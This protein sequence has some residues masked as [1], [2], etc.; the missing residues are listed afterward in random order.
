MKKRLVAL[1]L[2]LTLVVCAFPISAFAAATTRAVGMFGTRDKPANGSNSDTNWYYSYYTN[3]AYWVG[4]RYSTAGKPVYMIQAYLFADGEFSTLLDI[5]GYFGN[6]TETKIRA[7]QYKYRNDGLSEDG[8]AGG[9]TWKH[10]A[11]TK[12]GTSIAYLLPYA[13]TAS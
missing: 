13:P 4:W 3:T 10:M 2:V 5:D 12:Y 1:L 11:Y 9:D 8:V 7:Y 6:N